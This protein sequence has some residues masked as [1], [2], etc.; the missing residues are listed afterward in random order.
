MPC[1]DCTGNHCD[2]L[3]NNH[4]S[5][6]CHTKPNGKCFI[7]RDPNSS[8]HLVLPHDMENIRKHTQKRTHTSTTA[9]VQET[10][11]LAHARTHARTHKHACISHVL[12]L[13]HTHPNLCANGNACT[14][15]NS[16]EPSV[17]YILHPHKCTTCFE[18][19]LPL[20]PLA[21]RSVLLFPISTPC[22]AIPLHFLQ[23][24]Q[25]NAETLDDQSVYV[26]SYVP[27]LV[28]ECVFLVTYRGC[29]DAHIW[30]NLDMS[31]EGCRYQKYG[32]WGDRM[33]MWCFC[34]R[35]ICNVNSTYVTHMYR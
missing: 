18:H 11:T 15:E 3:I 17:R 34:S 19:V 20:P 28:D 24:K 10:H 22:D 31:Y 2:V 21:V 14:Y 27:R 9:F 33:V 7:R 35:E 25:A 16:R 26:S 32:S 6:K 13:N 5:G 12:S 29:A 23:V 4:R 30:P 8:E 1:H